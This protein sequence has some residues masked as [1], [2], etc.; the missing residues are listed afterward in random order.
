MKCKGIKKECDIAATKCFFMFWLISLGDVRKIWYH[1][2]I[3][4]VIRQDYRY[5][6]LFYFKKQYI[7]LFFK[8]ESVSLYEQ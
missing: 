4:T 1:L 6:H 8:T 7:F 2:L 5:F 3:I